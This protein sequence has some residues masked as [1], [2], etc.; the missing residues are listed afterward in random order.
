MT[1][2]RQTDAAFAVLEEEFR[3]YLID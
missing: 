3:Y 1:R 2:W